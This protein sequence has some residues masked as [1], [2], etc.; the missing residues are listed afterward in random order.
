MKT[1]RCKNLV[2]CI[3]RN[4]L[5]LPTLECEKGCLLGYDTVRFGSIVLHS[6]NSLNVNHNTVFVAD[7][8]TVQMEGVFIG[9]LCSENGPGSHRHK[10]SYDLTVSATCHRK[11]QNSVETGNHNDRWHACF[12]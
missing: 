10:L 5:G 9:T 2:F 1:P 11:L 4:L 3:V 12:V 7:Q 8:P 6:L